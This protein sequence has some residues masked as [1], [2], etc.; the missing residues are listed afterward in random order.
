MT[1]DSNAPKAPHSFV[2]CHPEMGVFLGVCLG[3][4]F[5]SKLDSVGQDHAPAFDS[6]AQAEVFMAGWDNGRPQGVTLV[7][8]LPDKDGY[9]S[10]ATC[11]AAG[12]PGWLDEQMPVANDIPA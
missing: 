5:W 9:A 2:I 1:S 7:P 11:V 10:V 12:L 8:V 6:E 3:L 4:A